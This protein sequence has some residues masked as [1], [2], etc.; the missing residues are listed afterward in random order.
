MMDVID[1]LIAHCEAW[2]PWARVMGNVCAGDAAQALRSLR[3]ENA[4][5][6]HELTKGI[7]TCGP[8]R[9]YNARLIAAAPDWDAMQEAIGAGDG[10]L[11]GAIE[12]WHEEALR[13]RAELALAIDDCR[14]AQV[15]RDNVRAAYIAEIDRLRAELAES[16]KEIVTKRRWRSQNS[17]VGVV[18]DFDNPL[19]EAR[20]LIALC[21]DDAVYQHI[22]TGGY[23]RPTQSCNRCGSAPRI[24]AL[25]QPARARGRNERAETGRGVETPQRAGI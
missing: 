15:E 13:L 16:K 7:H 19:R 4:V 8:N 20:L 9:D 10:T 11:H 23:N 3:A 24:L 17:E 18:W 25:T 12:Y 14:A 22:A 2:E 5:L 6:Q 1:E 21:N